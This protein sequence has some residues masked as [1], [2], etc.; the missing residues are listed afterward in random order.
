MGF[1]TLNFHAEGEVHQMPRRCLSQISQS[2]SY[3]GSHYPFKQGSS[4]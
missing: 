1:F 3:S 2:A 4:I